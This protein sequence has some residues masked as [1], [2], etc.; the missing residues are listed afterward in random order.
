MYQ[1]KAGL[2]NFKALM[3]AGLTMWVSSFLLQSLH[4]AIYI[5]QPSVFSLTLSRRK[6][7][8]LPPVL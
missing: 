4:T 6:N 8:T 1:E 7:F 3:H 5:P 2:F